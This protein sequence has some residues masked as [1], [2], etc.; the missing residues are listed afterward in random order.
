MPSTRYTCSSKDSAAANETIQEELYCLMPK[1]KRLSQLLTVDDTISTSPHRNDNNG[2]FIK[3]WMKW[4]LFG[5]V[6]H[7]KAAQKKSL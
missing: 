5:F 6:V 4:M 2:L 7:T 1:A 3:C